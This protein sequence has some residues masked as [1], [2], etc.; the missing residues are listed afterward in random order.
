MVIDFDF[1]IRNT[2]NWFV[3]G[4]ITPSIKLDY[5]PVWEEMAP[6][7]KVNTSL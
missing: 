4:G 6:F 3:Y 2:K 7:L 5:V 1:C